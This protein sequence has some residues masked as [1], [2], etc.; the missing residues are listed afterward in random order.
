MST[1]IK[2]RDLCLKS[3]RKAQLSVLASLVCAISL[4]PS[5]ADAETPSRPLLTLAS[6]EAG[7]SSCIALAEEN[8]WQ[9][10]ISVFDRSGR[11]VAFKR[12]DDVYQKQIEVSQL[13]A[14]TAATTPLSSRDLG[15]AVFASESS[16]RGVE[17]APGLILI[18]GGEPVAFSGHPIGGVGV[19]GST[20]SNDGICAR[21]AVKAIVEELSQ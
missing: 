16:L 4:V 20:P 19:S 12:M 17:H 6:A 21:A 15:A 8:K 13:K 18:E 10:A 2:Q 3:S 5:W 9:M 14:E 7:I 1:A 11:P